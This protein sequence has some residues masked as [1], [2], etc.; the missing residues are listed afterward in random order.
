MSTSSITNKNNVKKEETFGTII[1]L[2]HFKLLKCLRDKCTIAFI[3]NYFIL[4][5]LQ[6]E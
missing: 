4:N 1:M 3:F 5:I 2:R 6:K